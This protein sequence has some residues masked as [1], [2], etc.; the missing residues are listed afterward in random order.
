[1]NRQTTQLCFG[2]VGTPRTAPRQEGQA[3]SA[4]RPLRAGVPKKPDPSLLQAASP[5]ERGVCRFRLRL[6]ITKATI[7][8]S[9]HLWRL[10]GLLSGYPPIGTRPQARANLG[11]Q[12]RQP[13]RMRV[14]RFSSDSHINFTI[15][16]RVQQV[17]TLRAVSRGAAR[18]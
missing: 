14:K 16:A 10:A 7:M 6:P 13:Q 8:L 17:K 15:V 2:L 18:F 1:L 3:F 12:I 5:V 4:I 11:N 9:F